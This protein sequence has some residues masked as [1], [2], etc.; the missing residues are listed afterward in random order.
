MRG[1]ST[2]WKR[3]ENRYNMGHFKKEKVFGKSVPS[4]RPWWCIGPP[5]WGRPQP[6]AL[7]PSAGFPPPGACSPWASAVTGSRSAWT[8]KPSPPPARSTRSRRPASVD[9]CLLD[10]LPPPP[11]ASPRSSEGRGTAPCSPHLATGSPGLLESGFCRQTV[12]S[13]SRWERAKVGS[14]P[15][16][17]KGTGAEPSWVCGWLVGL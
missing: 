5:S 6:T 7:S 3:S 14:Y 9:R 15:D 12:C 4:S 16:G 13:G 11:A 10:P 1:S 8:R 17:W 2:G